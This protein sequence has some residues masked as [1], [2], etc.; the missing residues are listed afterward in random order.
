MRGSAELNSKGPA[1][2][3]KA[4]TGCCGRCLSASRPARHEPNPPSTS[5][6]TN[7]YLYPHHKTPKFTRDRS[8]KRNGRRKRYAAHLFSSTRRPRANLDAT[9]LL[10]LCPTG[11]TGGKTGGKAGGDSSGK[12]QKSHSAKAG[13]QVCGTGLGDKTR[14][15]KRIQSGCREPVTQS[16]RAQAMRS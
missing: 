7:Y 14:R 10:T 16:L 13:L 5:H 1:S 3:A 11:K 2:R 12:T 8:N 9:H 4:R 6:F 15:E